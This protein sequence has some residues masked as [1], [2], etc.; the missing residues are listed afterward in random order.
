MVL[1]LRTRIE[2]NGLKIIIVMWLSGDKII[3]MF[4][5]RFPWKV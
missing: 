1:V 5:E 4:R 3:T 2:S